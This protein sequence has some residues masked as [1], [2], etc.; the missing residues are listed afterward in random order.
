MEVNLILWEFH[1]FGFFFFFQHMIRLVSMLSL[2][3]YIFWSFPVLSTLPKKVVLSLFCLWNTFCCTCKLEVSHFDASANTVTEGSF[4]TQE[5]LYKFYKPTRSQSV[6]KLLTWRDWK[7]SFFS[8][9]SL[10][11]KNWPW[12]CIKRQQDF[13]SYVILSSGLTE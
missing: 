4:T 7:L 2:Q 9:G 11:S 6:T 5:I 10:L 13:R 3:W 12:L 1:G 8:S